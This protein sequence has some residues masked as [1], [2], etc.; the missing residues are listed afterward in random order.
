MQK[1][2][3]TKRIQDMLRQKP[4]LSSTYTAYHL[5]LE[6]ILSGEFR[7]GDRVPQDALADAFDMSRTPVRDAMIML[8]EEGYLDREGK[9]GYV[10][11][12][13]RFKEYCWFC[14]YR[15]LVESHAARRAADYMTEDEFNALR[16]N[17]RAFSEACD[18]RNDVRVFALDEE[19]HRMI[20]ESSHNIFLIKAYRDYREKKQFYFT[21]RVIEKTNYYRL[22]K[23]H[24]KIM[25]ALEE[26]DAE[27]AGKMMRKHL[28]NYFIFYS[29]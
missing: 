29:K 15:M 10:V 4:F 13:V 19:F 5:I 22:K 11:H 7:Q 21:S 3:Y 8:E 14:E 16:E 24:Q 26:N 28:G 27:A 12:T 20:V 2:K 9:S 18:Q 1:E 25:E 23:R 6:G 17:M